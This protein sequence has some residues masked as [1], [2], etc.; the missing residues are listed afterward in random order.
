MA[1]P[2]WIRFGCDGLTERFERELII[3]LTENLPIKQLIDQH[4]N[5]RK[6]ND[7]D[8]DDYGKAEHV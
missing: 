2:D 7:R 4:R 3:R 5:F 6:A 8:P 1:D